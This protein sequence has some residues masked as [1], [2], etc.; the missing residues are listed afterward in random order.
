MTLRHFQIF[1]QVCDEGGMTRAAEKIHIS[2]PSVSQA[3]KELEEHYG[4]RLFERLGKQLYLTAAGKELIHYAR[5]VVR[6]TA[7]AESTLRNLS[8]SSPLRI[9]ATL[10]I[11]ESFFIPLLARFKE[12]QPK[13][14]VYSC[15][16]NTAALERSLLR[17]D[18]DLALVEGTIGSEYLTEIP[19]MED[20][21]IFVT[22]P[23]PKKIMTEED[24]KSCDFITREA[25]SGTRNL[26]EQ[27]LNT[28]QIKPRII[29]VYNNS[30]SIKQAVMAGLGMTALSRRVVSQEL[31]EHRLQEVMVPGIRF[32][33]NFRLVHHCNKFIT[34]AL[35]SFMELSHVF[36][37][38]EWMQKC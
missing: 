35:R 33:R 27:T 32:Q 6:L 12:A 13:Q 17:D 3:I 22:A 29:G 34:P 18:L 30:A 36:A 10:T 1:L 16:H 31:M 2:Q 15:I 19:F 7:E 23:G 25:G 37:K 21:L 9:G 11:G 26:F 14:E 8:G 20:E 5:Y 4:V 24:L 38:G 28:H